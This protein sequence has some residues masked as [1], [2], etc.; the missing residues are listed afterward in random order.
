MGTGTATAYYGGRVATSAA[1]ASSPAGDNNAG[2]WTYA[3]AGTTDFSI[4]SADLHNPFLAKTTV[5]DSFYSEGTG[6]N[7]RYVGFLLNTTSY[8]GFTL[9][10]NGAGTMSGG[11]VTVYGYRKA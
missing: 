10:P 7:G 1:G 3:A 6:A 8:T 5:I 2:L 4:F 9:D 11:T